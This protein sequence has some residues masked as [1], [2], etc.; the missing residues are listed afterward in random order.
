[1]STV[2]LYYFNWSAAWS[3]YLP[4]CSSWIWYKKKN[5]LCWIF[6]FN[7]MY[8][9]SLFQSRQQL[10]Y[11]VAITSW[12]AVV[13]LMILFLYCFFGKMATESFAKICDRVFEMNWQKLPLKSQ[14]YVILMITN[15]QIPL[16]YHGFEV[17]VMDL[18]TFVRVRNA[19]VNC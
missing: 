11:S 13:G 15:M 18:N 5:P 6:R 16:Y 8:L 9:L 14:K 3:R 17:A 4:I 10:D 7:I 2:R 19:L 12:L 1:M